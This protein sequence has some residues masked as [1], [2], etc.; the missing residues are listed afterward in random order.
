MR[1][2]TRCTTPA[3]ALLSILA[4]AG[5]VHGQSLS[6]GLDLG[7]SVATLHAEQSDRLHFGTGPAL[8]VTAGWRLT[9]V[10]S[11]GGGLSWLRKGAEGTLIGFEE[12]LSVDIR[13]DYVQVPLV[14]RLR[15][16]G[17]GAL[18]PT[19]FGGTAV[20]F[21]TGC[22]VRTPP[23]ELALTLGCEGP[24]DQRATTDWSVLLGGGVDYETRRG[25][26][27]IQGRYDLGLTRIDEA[28]DV[29]FPNLKNRAFVVTTGW[30]VPVG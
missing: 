16:P 30:V 14:A 17:A 3:F 21:E 19:V 26:L 29:Q 11:V 22:D 12:P 4:A 7:V 18:R 6:L 28:P 23:S 13:L 15:L 24:E 5:P 25:S 9:D 27:R 20:A 2:T 8:G 1:I 10:L